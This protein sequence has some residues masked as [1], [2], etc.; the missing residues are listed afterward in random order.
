LLEEIAKDRFSVYGLNQT[1][2]AVDSGAC[3]IL[4]VTDSFIQKNRQNDTYLEIEQIM[5]NAE[6]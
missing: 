3:S 1:K 5:K 2:D 4:L 6:K